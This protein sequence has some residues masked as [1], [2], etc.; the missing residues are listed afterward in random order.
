MLVA[1]GRSPSPCGRDQPSGVNS[2][3][4]AQD[5]QLAPVGAARDLSAAAVQ[6]QPELLVA[7]L[8]IRVHRHA[9]LHLAGQHLRSVGNRVVKQRR[10]DAMQ[11]D[12]ILLRREQLRLEIGCASRLAHQPDLPLR[13]PPPLGAL[14]LRPRRVY[15]VVRA[16]RVLQM[17]ELG[18]ERLDLGEEKSDRR[19]AKGDTAGAARVGDLWLSSATKG[20]LA[21]TTPTG[22]S[23]NSARAVATGLRVGVAIPILTR[24]LAPPKRACRDS[25]LRWSAAASARNRKPSRSAS[26]ASARCCHT[27]RADCSCPSCAAAAKAT[28]LPSAAAGEDGVPISM[29]SRH[30]ETCCRNRASAPRT[31]TSRTSSPSA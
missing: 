3:L 1:V 10:H 5:T 8:T 9:L 24:P 31:A 7:Q 26:A 21:R 23:V 28:F 25:R 12:Q 6:G 13:L 11:M 4:Q 17:G 29:S 14:A 18:L 19:L 16:G 27:R 15:Y 30:C 2:R 22:G 20:P